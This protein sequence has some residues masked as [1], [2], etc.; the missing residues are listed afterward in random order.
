MILLNEVKVILVP[1]DLLGHS[2]LL[3]CHRLYSTFY[4]Y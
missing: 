2:F 4:I 3:V 1:V